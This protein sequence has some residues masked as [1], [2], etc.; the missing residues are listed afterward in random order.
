VLYV[1]DSENHRVRRVYA[2][3]AEKPSK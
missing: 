2:R 1:G 3:S